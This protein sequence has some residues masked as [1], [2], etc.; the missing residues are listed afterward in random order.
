MHIDTWR[1]QS[2]FTTQENRRLSLALEASPQAEKNHSLDKTQCQKE[3]LVTPWDIQ[4]DPRS[5]NEL[6][7]IHSDRMSQMNYLIQGLSNLE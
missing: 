5:S 4:E 6:G 1:E 3:V 2:E 7:P